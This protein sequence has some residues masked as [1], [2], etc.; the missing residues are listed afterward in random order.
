MPELSFNEYQSKAKETAL[1]PNVGKNP[2]YPALGLSGEAGEIANKIKKSNKKYISLSLF[3]NI[4]QDFVDKISHINTILLR[5]QCDFLQRAIV[6]CE[7]TNFITQYDEQLDT[8]IEKRK[9]TFQEWENAY[10]LSSYV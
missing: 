9:S 3:D 7:N 6:L 5:I 10:N 1:Y 8:C 4:P 2:Y